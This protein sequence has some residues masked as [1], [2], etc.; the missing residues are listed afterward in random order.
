MSTFDRYSMPS[1]TN[2]KVPAAFDADFE[3]EYDDSRDELL[4]LYRKGKKLQWDAED[5]IDWSQDL[6]PEN[7]SGLPDEMIPIHGWDGFR[8]LTEQERAN[9][10]RHYQS[11]QLSQF[12]HGEQ[13]ALICTARIV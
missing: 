3:F 12:M 10:R 4:S 11:W 9:V 5:R 8:K 2:W 1:E 7:P 6:D 13:G